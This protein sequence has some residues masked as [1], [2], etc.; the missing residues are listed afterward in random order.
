MKYFLCLF[1]L[2]PSF[3]F[4]GFKDN[5]KI[6]AWAQGGIDKLVER[7]IF[8]GNPDG[9]F[10]PDR[11]LNR[12]EFCKILIQATEVEPYTGSEPSF[13]DVK[14]TDWF[15]GYV[16]TAKREGWLS[17]Y[18]DGKFRPG[19]TL[20]RAEAAKILA[21]AFDLEVGTAYPGESW[22]ERY[23]RALDQSDLLAYGSMFEDLGSDKKPSRAEIAEQLHRVMEKKAK[24]IKKKEKE[25]TD[26]DEI[27]EE[28]SMVD[29][30]KMTSGSSDSTMPTDYIAPQAPES[31]VD[32]DAGDLKVSKDENLERY[33]EVAPG[34]TRVKAH[35]LIFSAI[36]ERV[37]IESFQFRRVGNGSAADFAQAW[38]EVDGVAMSEKVSITEDLVNIPLRDALTVRS[39]L[40]NFVLRVDV[41]GNAAVGSSRFVLFMPEW[42]GADAENRIGFFPFGGADIVIE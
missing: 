31:V 33:Y 14:K 37:R 28:V 13:P 23:F 1:L 18:P 7:G 6:P 15:F 20:N 16:E 9:T 8:S 36:G 41:A 26:E 30:P 3:V 19:N 29:A 32:E 35:S 4:A 39:A 10:A 2:L 27:E 25:E 34:A 11:A 38:I 12:A 40:R 42:I 21:G 5:H 17:G 22:F 24:K